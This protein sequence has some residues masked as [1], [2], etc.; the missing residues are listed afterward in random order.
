MKP[1]L[2][3]N[4]WISAENP[5]TEINLKAHREDVVLIVSLK[6]VFENLS[7]VKRYDYTNQ[8]VFVFSLWEKIQVGLNFLVYKF[9]GLLKEFLLIHD[10][11]DFCKIKTINEM[12]TRLLQSVFLNRENTLTFFLVDSIKESVRSFFLLR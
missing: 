7:T 4:A 12:T 10:Y 3:S 1:D 5:L 8:N 2:Y 9:Y 6:T 11:S